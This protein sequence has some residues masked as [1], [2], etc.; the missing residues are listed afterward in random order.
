MKLLNLDQ[1]LF[2][3]NLKNKVFKDELSKKFISLSQLSD[4]KNFGL[5]I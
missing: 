4:S 5:D 3:L 2:Y 1:A